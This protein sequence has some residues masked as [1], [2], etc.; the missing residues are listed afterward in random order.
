MMLSDLKAKEEEVFRVS[1][2]TKTYPM[3][4]ILPRMLMFTLH[5]PLHLTNQCDF[6]SNNINVSNDSEEILPRTDDDDN[7]N[8]NTAKASYLHPDSRKPPKCKWPSES[9]HVKYRN[10]AKWFLL[11]GPMFQ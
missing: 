11:T 3:K 8:D 10:Q 4:G 1:L 2:T 7:D 5:N 6:E 9:E